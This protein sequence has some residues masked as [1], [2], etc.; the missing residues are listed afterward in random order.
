MDAITKMGYASYSPFKN[1]RENVILSNK[2]TMRST[3]TPL[4]A[5]PNGDMPTMMFPGHEYVFPNSTKVT[6]RRMQYGGATQPS[7]DP[8]PNPIMGKEQELLSYHLSK[9]NRPDQKKFLGIYRDMAIS[10]KEQVLERIIQ[11]FQGTTSPNFDMADVNPMETARKGKRKCEDGGDIDFMEAKKGGR[12]CQDGGMPTNKGGAQG[13]TTPDG[14]Y[15]EPESAFSMYNQ[16]DN[17]GPNPTGPTKGPVTPPL[18]SNA[19]AVKMADQA[20]KQV[21]KIKQDQA[22]IARI[23]QNLIGEGYKLPKSTKKKGDLDGVLGVETQKTIDQFI[24]DRTGYNV[25]TG[26]TREEAQADAWSTVL[27]GSGIVSS[28]FKKFV[29]LASIPKAKMVDKAANANKAASVDMTS[30]ETEYPTDNF[31]GYTFGLLKDLAENYY[32]KYGR[33]NKKIEDELARRRNSNATKPTLF[34]TGTLPEVVI[35]APRQVPVTNLKFKV[36]GK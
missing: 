22:G 29:P 18:M 20:Q 31:D 32:K 12:K 35:S 23:Q 5:Y 6:E 2:I 24:A 34:V 8:N 33:P 4:M 9:L 13:Y 7:A 10:E 14:R 26:M 17:M 16:S 11:D 15:F 28:K 25:Q 36:T 27:A 1:N 21:D 30:K 19:Q 3:H